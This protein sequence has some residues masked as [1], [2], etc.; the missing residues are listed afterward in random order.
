MDVHSLTKALHPIFRID[1]AKSA[2]TAAEIDGLRAAA[3]VPLPPDYLAVVTE[4]TEVELLVNGK[5]YL[6]IWGPKRCIE[7]NAAYQI[8]KHIPRS[9]AIGDDEGG[10]ALVL[11]EGRT[12]NGLYM[13]DFSVLDA[14]D[15][16]FLASTLG[17]LLFKGFGWQSV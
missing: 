2:A 17:D 14:S 10:M 11:M 16:T 3:A 4:M 13:V 6:R 8:Q 15:A 5:K 9:L 12:G 7:M 1:G